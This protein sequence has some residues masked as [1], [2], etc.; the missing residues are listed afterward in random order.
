VVDPLDNDVPSEHSREGGVAAGNTSE[1]LDKYFA[2][3]EKDYVST[4]VEE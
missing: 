2:A 3:R 1:I 4:T